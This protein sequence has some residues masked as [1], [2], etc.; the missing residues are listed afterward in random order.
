MERQPHAVELFVRSLSPSGATHQQERILERLD[1]LA[2]E[3]RIDD[4]GM[5]VWGERVVPD[6]VAAET[7]TGES[8]LNTIEQ[9]QSWA[10]AHGVSVDQFYPEQTVESAIT[11][12]EF[13]AISLPVVAMAE[14]VDGRLHHV[15]PH[16]GE[17]V[18]TVLD[19][20][21]ALDEETERTTEQRP[22]RL[23]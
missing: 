7:A 3:G 2:T 8:V 12:E 16:E 17:T 14:Y 22:R 1:E 4:Y 11:G 5:T 19:R 21:D 20:L 23:A 9:F 18:Q 10:A 13:T 15:T 6:S